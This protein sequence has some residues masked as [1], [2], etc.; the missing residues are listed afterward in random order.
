MKNK[1]I[2]LLLALLILL[3]GCESGEELAREDK[4]KSEEVEKLKNLEE[5]NFILDWTPN[6]NH[7]GIF[8]ALEKGYYEDE[9][10]LVKIVQPP[11]GG[12]EAIVGTGYGDFGISF[13]DYLA[14]AITGSS[15][16][17]I[18]AVAAILQH[19]HSGIIS[20]K[21]EGMDRPK[22]L[23]G[24]KYATWDMAVEKSIIKDV[25]EEDG[26]DFEKVIKIPSTVLDEVTALRT[27][28]VD[29]IWAYYGWAGIAAKVQDFPLDYFAFK[30]IDDTF[31]F[32]SPVIIA[33]NELIK[34]EPEKVEK[35]LKA[36]KKGYEFA[37]ENPEE[38]AEILLDADSSLSEDLVKESQKWMVD[39]YVDE[40]VKWG[41]MDPERWE[42]FYSWLNENTLLEGEIEPSS[43]FTND[44]LP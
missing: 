43:G 9:G 21:G 40:G 2:L 33:S 32:Y 17:P 34:K 20:R 44:F 27:E 11:E 30:D 25:M 39:K 35:F 31:D 10:F 36:T 8:V 12:A 28:E 7:T 14:N 18:T 19:N 42:K 5:I 38:A 24:K 1:K 37:M 23:E 22:G 16:V 4:E 29:A 13:Q 41:Y 15:K 3:V 26:G 6:T